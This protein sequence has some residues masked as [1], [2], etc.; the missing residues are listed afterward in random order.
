MNATL[1]ADN[2][3]MSPAEKI[4]AANAAM[5]GHRP[6]E[7][8]FLLADFPENDSL[9]PKALEISGF[10]ANAQRDWV[11]ASPLWSKL[12]ELQ[13]HRLGPIRQT[14]SAY[15]L[16][17]RN[18]EGLS[19]ADE[20]LIRCSDKNGVQ[21]E[22]MRLLS[23]LGRKDDID[24]IIGGVRDYALSARDFST[25]L[26][27]ARW[28][29]DS[30]N[31]DDA[32]E[33]F[34]ISRD[35]EPLRT[36]PELYMGRL[37][38]SHGRYSDAKKIWKDLIEDERMA[39]ANLYEPYI[40]LA[41]ISL[42]EN[43]LDSAQMHLQAAIEADYTR[44]E[45]YRNLVSIAMQRRDFSRAREVGELFAEK[46]PD[47]GDSLLLLAE[48]AELQQDIAGSNALWTSLFKKFGYVDSWNLRY[49]RFLIRQKRLEDAYNFWEAREVD[50]QANDRT[51][52]ERAYTRYLL[53]QREEALKILVDE[54][55][56]AETRHED[57]L[58]L[59]ANILRD[60]HRRSE[61]GQVHEKATSLFPKNSTFW[62]GAVA[63]Y[64]DIDSGDHVRELLDRVEAI[65]DPETPAG[66][67]ALGRISR[68]AEQ[69]AN[70][71]T[72]FTHLLE[73]EPSHKK[74]RIIFMRMLTQLGRLQD[75]ESHARIIR[76][77]D[78]RN[79]EATGILARMAHLKK[80]GIIVEPGEQV[81]SSIFAE[82]VKRDTSLPLPDEA[83]RVAVLT[84]SLGS[85][86]AERQVAYT[87]LGVGADDDIKSLSFVGEDLSAG[88]GRDFFKPDIEKTSHAIIDME[89]HGRSVLIREAAAAFPDCHD[90]IALLKTLPP[91]IANIAAP[92]YAWLKLNPTD[93]VHTW[94]DS[95]NIAGGYAALLAGVPKIILATRSTRPDSR[96]RFR[97]T[98]IPGYIKLMSRPEVSI[99]NNSDIGSRDYEDWLGLP[100]GSITTIHNGMDVVGMRKRATAR[101]IAKVQSQ[102]GFRDDALILGGVMR[103]TEE[104]RPEL[105]IEVAI[106]A[107][108][109]DPL[110]HFVLV[111]DGP[112]RTGLIQ[113][114]KK[115]GLS[116]QIVFAGIQQP[117]EPWMCVFDMLFLSSRMEGLPNV[118][119]EAQALGTPIATMAVGGAV[120]TVE[121]GV[122]GIL[123]EDQNPDVIASKILI[124]LYD[125][126]W[127]KKASV[128]GQKRIAERFSIAAMARKTRQIYAD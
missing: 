122:T 92:F 128:L 100:K 112:M 115:E 70:A 86:G 78:W 35:F 7:A 46:F 25:T 24:E 117:I 121:D 49:S 81:A 48:T 111:G 13:P 95:I 125:I 29:A 53:D 16:S 99:I 76:K 68:A 54:L 75:A 26:Q 18:E 20:A 89:E 119:L 10:A 34:K 36:D 101:E 60:L 110:L 77:T 33:L 19:F 61:A 123:I 4:E 105:F 79:T 42:S 63:Y 17:G 67:Y 97:P 55:K 58:L 45:P 126:E 38:Y 120:E 127:R 9:Y 73:M 108:K 69:Y 91:E 1:E 2:A 88:Y 57:G 37:L 41:R 23:A 28:H 6:A 14:V 102:L 106:N 107:A 47:Q 50:G 56:P 40:F 93:V 90:D 11:L 52:Y 44:I 59:Q 96:R 43:D 31:L 71:E 87:A 51:R 65:F 82:I 118:L 116:D 74:G 72:H 12:S 85:G 30:G 103:F 84:S 22:R 8:L 94:Q 66:R 114:V 113:Q 80:Q 3:H 5:S 104:K 124:K 21:V 32:I 27:L 83:R 39:S 64:S 98:L 109:R 15:M 62:E